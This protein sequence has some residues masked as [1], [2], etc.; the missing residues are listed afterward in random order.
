MMRSDRLFTT[1]LSPESPALRKRFV[2]ST[3]S[4]TSLP[5]RSPAS[6]ASCTLPRRARRSARSPRSASR[7]RTRPSLRVR[8]ACMPLRI[9]T[10]SCAQN[11]S[12]LRFITSSAASWSDLRAS[13][14]AKLPGYERSRPRSSSMM[15]VATLSRNARSW[16]IIMAD[17]TAPD[18]SRSSSRV[19]P[20]ISRWL[21]GSSSSSRSGFFAKASASIARLRSPPEA[22]AV[23]RFSSRPKRCRN[24]VS[25]ASMAQ[26]S[27]S[28]CSDSK[29]AASARLSRNVAASGGEDSC[30]TV[31]MCR[32]SSPPSTPLSS[33]IWP[34]M[35]FSSDDL[36]VPLR[37]MR[38]MRSL[39]CTVRFARSSNGVKPKASSASCKV[40]RAME[41]KPFLPQ[42]R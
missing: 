29:S 21:V 7:R 5:E 9:H 42:R 11:L 22:V 12:N 32:P 35:I 28:S 4:A 1:V 31:A 6:S 39:G 24:S 20:E 36:P 8:R 14:A 40:S 19:M 10:S 30:S 37:P 41:L 17:L 26:R 2:T 34:A 33:G 38:P 27:R 18:T 13:Y 25:R 23:G 3:S 16:V 15:R